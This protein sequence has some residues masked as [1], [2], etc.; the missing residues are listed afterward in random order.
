MTAKV[1]SI[2]CIRP[3]FYNVEF[4]EERTGRTL[5]FEFDVQDRDIPVIHRREEFID[6]VGSFEKRHQA[7][8]HAVMQFHRACQVDFL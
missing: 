8:M 6:Y 4:V 7:L 5:N 1:R 2:T 3:A